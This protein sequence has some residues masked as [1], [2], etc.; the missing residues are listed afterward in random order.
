MPHSNPFD[1]VLA[2]HYAEYAV[3]PHRVGQELLDRL[4]LVA[5]QPKVIVD[6]GCGTGELTALLQKR[7]PMA[8]IHALD[9]VTAF[10]EYAKK[11]HGQ[12]IHWEKA[13]AEQ[14]PFAANSVDLVYANLVLP[15]CQDIKRV[16]HEWQ[17][18]LRPEG[19]LVFTT[20]GPDTLSELSAE[21]SPI[22]HFFDMHD[23][24]DA[25]IQAEFSDPIMDVETFTLSYRDPKTL[26]QELHI[27]GMIESSNAAIPE[28]SVTFEVV[29]GHAWKS[30]PSFTADETG[31]VKIPLEEL[32]KRLG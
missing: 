30:S 19:L 3:L 27:L 21:I 22:P 7:Y 15:W 16:F 6:V 11:T 28:L 32:R 8:V 25:L 4:E 31:V 14:L 1:N 20:L 9:T 29:F 26:L 24:G 23:V 10:L 2:N 13:S 17:R 12:T 5:M 18:V